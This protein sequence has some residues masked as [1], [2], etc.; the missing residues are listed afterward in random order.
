MRFERNLPVR[1]FCFEARHFIQTVICVDTCDGSD[2]NDV[3]ISLTEGLRQKFAE[4]PRALA[5]I[6]GG[7]SQFSTSGMCGFRSTSDRPRFAD[8][9]REE[10][11]KTFGMIF[12]IGN[13]KW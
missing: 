10:I 7:K 5:V 13:E 3:P 8:P 6:G 4:P 1:M 11:F 9:L 12:K 2:F